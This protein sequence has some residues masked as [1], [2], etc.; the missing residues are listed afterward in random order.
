MAKTKKLNLKGSN[1]KVQKIRTS[2]S[3]F[4]K[5]NL[6]VPLVVVFIVGFAF[7]ARHFLLSHAASIKPQLSGV[8]DRQGYPNTNYQSVVNGFVVKVNWADLQT[9]QG[10]AITA[11]NA[12]D[13]ALAY[14]RSKNRTS[15]S[16]N[17]RIK[18]RVYAGVNAPEW[19]KNIGGSPLVVNNPDGS[20]A[21]VGRW[22]LPAYGSAYQD[23]QN[24]L[25]AK[26]DST[27]EILETAITRCTTT[28]GE[29][30]LREV[31]NANNVQTY[32]NAGFTLAQDQQ[33]LRDQIS[34][35]AVWNQTRSSLA[36]NPYQEITAT[37]TQVDEAFT[38]Q[39]MGQ[40]R[41]VLASR[42]VLGNNSILYPITNRGADY[43]KMYAR[44]QSYG[45]PIYFQTATMDKVGDLGQTLS[46]AASVGAGMVELP[47]GYNQ[48]AASQLSS[49]D[50][51]LQ[52]HAQ[53]GTT[54]P[55]PAPNPTPTPTPT[56]IPT[57]IPTP[58]ASSGNTAPKGWVDSYS[59]NH[60]AGWAFDPD[61]TSTPIHI[62]FRVNALSNSSQIIDYGVTNVN[63]PDV[64][65]IFSLT[66]KHGFDWRLPRVYR[67]GAS[68]NI[69]VFA[70]DSTTGA[71]VQIGSGSVS[72]CNPNN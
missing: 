51:Q 4:R 44:I 48:Y 23:L 57:P 53:S 68:H 34:E 27:P 50:L 56:P 11:N 47:A 9:T 65:S 1:N 18:L 64:N 61:T 21:T 42:C 2:Q 59:C 14:A 22:W 63:R 54:N 15:A 40:C 13:K 12:I 49:Y 26:Y 39:M 29:P 55:T 8:I 52:N 38:E 6:Q 70:V 41:S 17:M 60:T 31:G 62:S 37:G 25:A 43:Q 32:R 5:E 16:L 46:W 3:I 58:P 35:H 20:V 67:D 30:F 19:A 28:F 24:K 33:C 66:G 69:Y 45:P 71:S 10:G 7:V 72:G 36:L